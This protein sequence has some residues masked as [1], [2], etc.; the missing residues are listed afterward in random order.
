MTFKG[1]FWY[2]RCIPLEERRTLGQWAKYC[3][4]QDIFTPWKTGSLCHY[5][6]NKWN[7]SKLILQWKRSKHP[8]TKEKNYLH[9]YSDLNLIKCSYIPYLIPWQEL[10]DPGLDVRSSDSKSITL[11]VTLNWHQLWVGISSPILK[12]FPDFLLIL[13]VSYCTFYP[14]NF[15]ALLTC[16]WTIATAS[17]EAGL[18]AFSL[19]STP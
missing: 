1:S 4:H 19:S 11:S 9:L 17:T 5:W 2:Y 3:L 18:F 12:C 13:P 14:L 15:L 8:K 6:P 16:A 7:L 10:M